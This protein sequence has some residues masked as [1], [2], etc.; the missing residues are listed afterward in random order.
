[1]DPILNHFNPVLQ[2]TWLGSIWNAALG[3]NRYKRLLRR[4]FSVIF[5]KESFNLYHLNILV[6]FLGRT[7]FF[8]SNFWRLMDSNKDHSHNKRTCIELQNIISTSE[9]LKMSQN[10]FSSKI[11]IYFNFNAF[12]QND[13]N[14]DRL[15]NSAKR[16]FCHILLLVILQIASSKLTHHL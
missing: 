16:Y 14:Y 11:S 10:R 12:E 6:V 9:L 1:M 5:S 13:Q 3:W 4:K 7:I 15:K 2:I 8:Q